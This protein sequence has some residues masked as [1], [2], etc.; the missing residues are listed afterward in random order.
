MRSEPQ[1]DLSDLQ[2]VGAETSDQTQKTAEQGKTGAPGSATGDQSGLV[3]GLYA[4]PVIGR[5][6]LPGT[7]CD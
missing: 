1:A 6:D 5:Q 3:N 2:G 4:R 7:Q